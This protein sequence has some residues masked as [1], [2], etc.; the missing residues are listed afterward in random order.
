MPVV[1]MV[2]VIKVIGFGSV[3]NRYIG[4]KI[5]FNAKYFHCSCHVTWLP[6][7]TSI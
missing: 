1:I 4:R 5:P 3:E 2:K 7:K 6:S